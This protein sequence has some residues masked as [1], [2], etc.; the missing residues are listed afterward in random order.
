MRTNSHTAS[1]WGPPMALAG[2]R[3]S[4]S[5]KTHAWQG[6]TTRSFPGR[7]S[8]QTVTRLHASARIRLHCDVF[9]L[10][11]GKRKL[12]AI[13][14]GVSMRLQVP[15][16]VLVLSAS[17][18]SDPVSEGV[19]ASASTVL[20]PLN[21]APLTQHFSLLATG[22]INVGTQARVTS[23][24][25]GAGSINVGT[26]AGIAGNT[27]APTVALGAHAATADIQT[28][29]LTAHSKATHGAVVPLTVALPAIPAATATPGSLN[30]SVPVHGVQTLAAGAYRDVTVGTWGTLVLS[31]GRYD[32]R[33]L[34]I[35]TLAHLQASQPV[36]IH[37]SQTVN[38]STQSNTILAAG[39]SANDLR[40]ESIGTGTPI[41]LGTQANVRALLLAPQGT[42]T[43]ATLAAL[44]GAIAAAAV[45]LGTLASVTFQDGI[46]GGQGCTPASCDDANPCTTDACVGAG[47]VNTAVAVGTS[48]ADATVC[49]GAETCNAAGVCTAGTPPQID[50]GNTCTDDACDAS[51]GVTHT[52]RAEG[53]ACPDSTVCNGAET[54]N[55]S[56][57]CTAGAPPVVD[58]GN[59]CTDDACDAVAGVTHTPR[60]V[61]SACPDTTVCN[62]AETCGATGECTAGAPPIVADGNPCTVDS[63]DPTL[64][65]VHT[66]LPPDDACHLDVD[67]D[68]DGFTENHGDCDDGNA[69]IHP[70]AA[71]VCGNGVDEDCSAGDLPCPNSLPAP[72]LD[73]TVATQMLELGSFLYSGTA[74]VQTGVI[75]GTIDPRRA[76][77]LRGRVKGIL[78]QP[79][80]G[81]TIIVRD[82][83][84][85]GATLTRADG[86]FDLAVNGGGVLAVRYGKTG[87]LPLQRTEYVAWQEFTL[88]PDVVLIAPNPDATAVD[89]TSPN[90][91]VA[92]GAEVSD[93]DG[94]RRP[95]VV[96]VPGTAAEMVFPDLSTTPISNLTVR[97]TEY[98]VGPYGRQAM[99]LNLPP[100]SD[101]T[102]AI[103]L[104]IDEADAAG[105]DS[106]AFSQ[107]VRLYLENFIGLPVGTIV[108]SG[109]VQ[110]KCAQWCGEP[111]G[112][113][114][115]LVS[116]SAGMA[117]LDTDGDDVAESS[118]T[119]AALGIL[120]V[121]RAELANH[122]TAGETLWRVPLSHFSSQDLN[123][124][125]LIPDGSQPGNGGGGGGSVDESCEAEGSII[126]IH[127]QVLG[128]RVAIT[129]TPY[130]LRYASDRV[131]GRTAQFKTPIILSEAVVPPDLVRIVLDIQ[132]AG[133]QLIQDFPAAPDQ[134]TTFTWDGRDG[135]GRLMQGRQVAR[136]RL[137]YVYTPTYM[138][139]SNALSSFGMTGLLPLNVT[140]V[141]NEVIRWREHRVMLGGWDAKAL[142]LG[143]FSL[144]PHNA[145]GASL[146]RGVSALFKGDGDEQSA[147]STR[148]V[149]RTVAGNRLSGFTGDNV[150]GPTTRLRFPRGIALDAEGNLYIADDGNHRIR[151]VQRDGVIVTVAGTGTN[152]FTPDGAPAVTSSIR[153]PRDVAVGP[154]GSLFFWEGDAGRIRK[155]GMDGILTTVAGGGALGLNNGGAATDAT[156]TGFFNGV[157]V[158]PDGTVYFSDNGNRRIR[159]VD[160]NGIIHTIAGTGTDALSGDGGLAIAA[161]VGSVFGVAVG[162]DGSIYLAATTQGRIRRISPE[163]IITTVAGGGFG[164]DGTPAIGANLHSPADVA[165]SAAGELFISGGDGVL[166]VSP[167]GIISSLTGPFATSRFE[168]GGRSNVWAVASNGIAKGPDGALYVSSAVG[169]VVRR[170]DNGLPFSGGGN[171]V[172][173]SE[174]GKE[175]YVLDSAGRHLRTVD[176]TTGVTT[177]TFGYTPGGLLQTLTD[178][179]GLVTM[180]ERDVTGRPTAI[181]APHGERTELT[182]DSNGRLATI[183][184]P[185]NITRQFTYIGSTGLLATMTN[186][187]GGVTDFEYDA[188]G[189]LTR[190]NDAADGFLTLTRTSTPDGFSVVTETA[191][192]RVTQ[193]NVG[194]P[195]AGGQTRANT[196]PSGLSTQVQ[197]AEAGTTSI[198][199]PDNTLSVTT[200]TPDPRFGMQSPIRSI[201]ET[202]PSGR[203]R[204]LVR[205]RTVQ[206][207]DPMDPFSVSSVVDVTR[208]NGAPTTS[209]YLSAS[210]TLTTTTTLGRTAVTTLDAAGRVIQVSPAGAA[211]T[212]IV[213]DSGG[214]PVVI[215]TGAGPTARQTVLTYDALGRL[216]T[217]TDP[218]LRVTRYAYDAAGRTTLQTLP[219]NRDVATTYDENGNIASIAPPG[220]PP[221][222]FEYTAVDLEQTYSPPNLGFSPRETSS[223]YNDDRQLTLMSYPDGKSVTNAY[224]A[225]G[226][227][228]TVAFGSNSRTHV[229]HPA[230]GQLTR[231]EDTN[232]D[233]LAF[234]YDGKLLAGSTWSGAVNGSVAFTF[235]N[236]FRVAQRTV[237]GGSAVLLE[238]DGDGL[239][240][241]AGALQVSRDVVSGRVTGTRLGGLLDG[242]THNEFGEV[243]DYVAQFDTGILLEDVF[244]VSY[245]RDAL[246]RITTMVE[247][248]QGV[249]H[250][251]SFE[252]DIAG[253]L[254]LVQTDGAFTS[255]YTYDSNGNRLSHVTPTGTVTAD[256]DSQD[257]MLRYADYS[258]S[259]TRNGELETKVHV[260]T[261]ATTTFVYDEFSNLRQV[262]MPNGDQLEY[263][264]DGRNRR[265]GKKVNGVMTQAFLYEDQLRIAAE[266]DATGTIASVFVYSG[267]LNSPDY[268]AKAGVALRV[269]KDHLGSPRVVVDSTTGAVAQRMDFDEFGV[270]TTESPAA[271]QPFGFAG[272]LHDQHTKLTRF[273]TRD[274]D[275]VS[276]RWT[277]KDPIRFE[278]GDA[279]LF[280]YAGE[281]PIDNADPTGN[282]CE[283]VGTTVGYEDDDTNDPNAG[284]LVAD[285]GGSG[286]I[287]TLPIRTPGCATGWAIQTYHHFTRYYYSYRLV[288]YAF[289]GEV[290]DRCPGSSVFARLRDATLA[291]F[292]VGYIHF[293]TICVDAPPPNG[294]RL[295][296]R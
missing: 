277:S 69:S 169:H 142:G 68:G 234:S 28:N 90:V 110:R 20:S 38:F 127:N 32:F 83:P 260:P 92:I 221:H 115:K 190:D 52:A 152:A 5:G 278:G 101:Y 158:G 17:S 290:G 15:L 213:Y 108:P 295:T 257:R 274:Y 249:T 238:Y 259:Y 189:R 140:R 112:L 77:I 63:C 47:C 251:R 181:I 129:G 65:V 256:Y 160:C 209:E 224:D 184:G 253:R 99:P 156:L 241:R 55:E 197:S 175:A 255:E 54:C 3:M 282:L 275:A 168:E 192:S 240:T 245:S 75:A 113:V 134:S 2:P 227:L 212:N 167:M 194:S 237:N 45:T 210:R 36:E 48:C 18:C 86:R 229:Y 161:A 39:L 261:G 87:Y 247:I 106:V 248:I 211:A 188:D 177:L 217:V 136:I 265:V 10:H 13:L 144:T 149:V 182:L 148:N 137:G 104:G 258:Y 97:L 292:D 11:H 151:K 254:K 284:T 130:A 19:T 228:G 191:E 124:P 279:N 34:T 159:R 214:R 162:P 154:D 31:G 94:P 286:V 12:P 116:I 205:S 37:V 64:G 109:T 98:T 96:V 131:A 180:V 163:G 226:R 16:F 231:V 118:A 100:E 239:L 155:I 293:A 61:G 272:G 43:V 44:N 138:S 250:T 7:F 81:V 88:L 8:A 276:G 30:V 70:S 230:T 85:Y 1:S 150:Q 223:E 56:G 146:E 220:R 218:L 126:D 266:L 121:E 285:E 164:G 216:E 40:I 267:S 57:T 268:L 33:N 95:L 79:L 120:D 145:Y 264:I 133:Q 143:G 236:N 21:S 242:F 202:L 183:A 132:V 176:P 196:W 203:V 53:A 244:H 107:P 232:G 201:K 49:N 80:E 288:V 198:Q 179:N 263:V 157:A 280:S 135:Y 62:G 51:A 178:R 74:P 281:D 204:N 14:Q 233:A 102:Y 252:Y 117:D 172:V 123:L 166:R 58:D 153:S 72:P 200:L 235:D 105:A 291:D 114:I 270:V 271:F 283:F 294:D 225:A 289:R 287:N 42:V 193:F 199:R 128:E 84:E 67:D 219:G 89:L 215:T 141:G 222:E 173:A 24:D 195:G 9:G 73:R 207:D 262:G 139:P 185:E 82:H 296:C 50:D 29:A 46:T 91:Q 165:V 26:K 71:E 27:L 119:Y 22:A 125:E 76:A 206:L 246:G 170:I 122:Y 243:S 103:E 147:E 273:G 23:G 60:P 25:V 187:R 174:N 269:L 186:P 4:E 111:N 208:L 41:T 6:R 78:G 59:V 171:I 35:G 66:P 93:A